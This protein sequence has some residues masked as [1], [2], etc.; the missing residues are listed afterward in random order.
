MVRGPDSIQIA[1]AGAR[2]TK[3]MAFRSKL[4]FYSGCEAVGG[5]G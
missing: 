3:S 4:V 2:G 1:C 5:A